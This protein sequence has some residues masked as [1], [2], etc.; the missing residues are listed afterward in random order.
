MEDGVCSVSDPEPMACGSHGGWMSTR[1]LTTAGGGNGQWGGGG[2]MD[3]HVAGYQRAGVRINA[4]R[5]HVLG[6]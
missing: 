6:I 4:L 2:E 5:A 1:Y 3:S